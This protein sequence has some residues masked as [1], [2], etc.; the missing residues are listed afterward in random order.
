MTQ[1]P[2]AQLDSEPELLLIST[3]STQQPGLVDLTDGPLFHLSAC[4]PLTWALR[5]DAHRG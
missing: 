1:T 5:Y 3:A 2:A 4:E